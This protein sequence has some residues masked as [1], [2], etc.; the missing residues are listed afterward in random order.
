MGVLAL[1]RKLSEVRFSGL[2]MY[3]HATR[4]E[5]T[6]CVV[7]GNPDLFSQVVRA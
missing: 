3:R 4:K 1:A 5:S 6:L 7:F 2:L